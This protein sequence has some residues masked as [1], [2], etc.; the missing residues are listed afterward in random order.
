M[1]K[2]PREPIDPIEQLRGDPRALAA[3]FEQHRDRLRRRVELRLDPRLRSRLDAWDVVQDAFLD[4]ARGL[5]A[6]LADPK[7]SRRSGCGC[8]S[9]GG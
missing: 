7:L 8:T 9:A 3:L 5:D 4:V 6:N 1:D 2:T